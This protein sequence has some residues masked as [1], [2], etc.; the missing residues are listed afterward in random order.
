MTKRT[1]SKENATANAP[2]DTMKEPPTRLADSAYF[3][4]VETVL[5]LHVSPVLQ[6]TLAWQMR[7]GR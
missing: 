7:Q 5:P 2:K 4:T 3:N 1:C 6:D